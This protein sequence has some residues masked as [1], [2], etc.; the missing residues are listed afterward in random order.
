MQLLLKVFLFLAISPQYALADL[1]CQNDEIEFRILN[2]LD[3]QYRVTTL[4]TPLSQQQLRAAYSALDRDIYRQV[5]SGATPPS[6]R[7]VG[8]C[9]VMN[10]CRFS[11][12]DSEMLVTC[13]GQ[14]SSAETRLEVVNQEDLIQVRCITS[15]SFY[16]ATLGQQMNGTNRAR[17]S[18]SFS[19]EECRDPETVDSAEAV[20]E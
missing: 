14:T 8:N 4:D 11:S 7:S 15:G 1:I 13:E 5:I 10:L 9:G 19:P 20:V 3:G 12:D 18:F 6:P 2:S 16:S 17:F